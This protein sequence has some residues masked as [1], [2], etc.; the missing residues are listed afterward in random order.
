MSDLCRRT[1][2]RS[3]SLIV[4]QHTLTAVLSAEHLLTEN[5]RS[6]TRHQLAIRT[7]LER[8]RLMARSCAVPECAHGLC[9]LV[10]EAGQ[11]LVQLKRAKGEHEPFAVDHTSVQWEWSVR[12][13][14]AV[15]VGPRKVVHGF[16]AEACV[17]Y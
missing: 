10:V 15:H 1:Q 12:V 17:L 16:E 7:P 6:S 3:P 11:H 14:V 13:V 9:G 4:C 5:S 8:D 2:S